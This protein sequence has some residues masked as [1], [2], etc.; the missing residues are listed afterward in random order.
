MKYD[1]QTKV[2]RVSQESGVF[3]VQVHIQLGTGKRLRIRTCN[4]LSTALDVW[5]ILSARNRWVVVAD[6]VLDEAAS[7][8]AGCFT[9]DSRYQR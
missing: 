9:Y 7:V 8:I 3:G 4:Q 2:A 1:K 6:L 5:R